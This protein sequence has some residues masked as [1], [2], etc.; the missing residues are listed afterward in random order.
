MEL[1]FGIPHQSKYE[2]QCG[3]PLNITD[4]VGISP[5]FGVILALN[6]APGPAA[7][8]AI[9]KLEKYSKLNMLQ[10]Q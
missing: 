8:G 3:E 10:E 4:K 6:Y 5:G 1:D 7:P 2:C 9:N